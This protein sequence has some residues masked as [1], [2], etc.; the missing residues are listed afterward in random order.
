MDWLD[1]ELLQNSISDWLLAVVVTAVVITL[2]YLFKTIVIYRASKLAR[3]TVNRVDDFIIDILNH[4]QIWFLLILGF[5]IGSQFLEFSQD[6]TR[7]ISQAITI[8]VFVQVAVWGNSAINLS[9]TH[10]RQERLEEDAGSVTVLS[11]LSLVGR[12]ILWSVVLLLILDNLGV[13]VTSLIAGLGISGIAVALAV[14]N[15]LGDLFA[16]L[17]I[18]LDKPFV[19][20]DAIVVGDFTGTVE[21]IGLKTT[22]LRSLSGE[23]LVFSNSDLLSSRIRNFKRMQERRIVFSFGVLYE[24]PPDKLAQI[25][26]ML[27]EIVENQEQARFDRAHFRSLDDSALTYEVVYYMLVPD[28]AVYMDTQQAINLA[29]VRRFATEGV[30]FAYPTQTLLVKMPPE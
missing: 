29:L 9:L 15:I 26:V 24:T 1:N 17:S 3:R 21:K 11:G 13:E 16:S 28:Y 12:L 6:I 8:T 25:P 18:V 23:Q 30:E 5:Y 14:Q 20:G 19:M 27:Q 10:Y 7:I 22:R 2:F 4:T